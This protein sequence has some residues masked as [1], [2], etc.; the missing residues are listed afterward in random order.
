MM[1]Q[2]KDL[3][4]GSPSKLLI[5]LALPIL[6]GSL[7]QQAYTLV[8]TFI[9]GKYVN[10]EA[11]T[12]VSCTSWIYWLIIGIF[13]GFTQGFSILIS[14]KYGAG[15]MDE[16]RKCITM[17]YLLAFLLTIIVTLCSLISIHGL[18]IL[19]HTPNNLIAMAERYL[20]IISAGLI[21]TT[22]YNLLSSILRAVGDTKTGLIA[23]IISS[24]VNII[25]DIVFVVY[26]HAG[27]SGV[28]AA[29]L[30]AQGF[31]C[32]I[33]SISMFKI[34][35]IKLKR[36]DWH[37]DFH[38][39]HTLFQLG[40]PLALQNTV[41]SIGGLI[42]QRIVN[43]YGYL[44]TA[45][46]SLT[47]KVT[48]LLQQAG[49]SF[50]IALGT[51]VGQN[52]GANKIDRVKKGVVNC[53]KINIILGV[54]ISILFSVFGKQ[55]LAAFLSMDGS[56]LDCSS[57]TMNQEIVSMAYQYLV[58]QCIFLLAVYLLFTYRAALL[59]MGYTFIPMLSGFVELAI[60]LV[61]AVFLPMWLGRTG[62]FYADG[63]AWVGAGLLLMISYYWRMK[64]V[65]T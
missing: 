39:F 54:L 55:V 28:A 61:V 24:I 31:S 65:R 45:A 3:T 44:F 43:S 36:S 18:L 26:F 15:D 42:M 35:D 30:I 46:V 51:Y 19:L 56:S 23:L 10:T 59:G 17:S 58:I 22:L 25:L 50:S 60:R 48:V 9:L 7:I 4:V 57:L 14:Q 49:V 37:F 32:I 52:L 53:L 29:T 40:A 33:C 47:G 2:S 5:H 1:I 8:D 20:M 38:N 11:L 27:V 34:P 21:I 12:A 41:I 13:T 64:R 62:V 16:M 63:L 6:V